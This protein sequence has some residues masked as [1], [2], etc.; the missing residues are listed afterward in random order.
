MAEV[1]KVALATE[2]KQ[3]ALH[4]SRLQPE[5]R[6]RAS[7][8]RLEADRMRYVIAR[9]TR[10]EIIG[11]LLGVHPSRLV[12][13]EGPY[14]KPRMRTN[15]SCGLHF[16]SS[17]SGDWILHAFDSDEVG[18]D[19]EQIRPEM[20]MLDD[21]AWVLSPEERRFVRAAEPAAR[22]AAMATVWVRKEAY[23]KAL[24]AG[25]QRELTEIGIIAGGNG[26]PGLAFDRG[27]GQYARE[28]IFDDI[29]IDATHKACVVRCA[30]RRTLV[31]REY[32]SAEAAHTTDCA[33]AGAAAHSAQ[34]AGAPSG[35]RG[36]VAAPV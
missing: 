3:I 30:P 12:F 4:E 24:G 21:F 5:E 15:G 20:A 13:D 18:V 10:S 27:A 11:R 33:N 19:V 22:A 9:S 2:A 26:K 7:R 35:S 28:W 8:F 1:W 31:L 6:E 32:D 14:G 29:E 36:Y 25:L 17:H 16:N 23:V 34:V